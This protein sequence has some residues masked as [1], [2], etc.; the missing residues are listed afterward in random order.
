MT[1]DVED[2]VGIV[3]SVLYEGYHGINNVYEG[4]RITQN[5]DQRRVVRDFRRWTTENIYRE[6]SMMRK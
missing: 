3:Q 1:L 5:S 2:T 4:S 6:A